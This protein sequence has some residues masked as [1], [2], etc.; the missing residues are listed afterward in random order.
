MA[1]AFQIVRLRTNMNR[2]L[3]NEIVQHIPDAVN[4]NDRSCEFKMSNEVILDLIGFP[5]SK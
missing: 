3:D 1:T 2:T 4:S 5:L